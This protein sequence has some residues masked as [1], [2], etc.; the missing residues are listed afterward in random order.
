[1]LLGNYW[2]W[3]FI[4]DDVFG[5]Q[6]G[7]YEIWNS[8][9]LLGIQFMKPDL[10]IS[11]VYLGNIFFGWFYRS[12]QKIYFA[13][14]VAS[15]LEIFNAWR[16]ISNSKQRFSPNILRNAVINGDKKLIF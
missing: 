9:F 4:K 10:V 6:N 11:V 8:Q 3:F 16:T 13:R 14:D 2:D 12:N 1:M 5:R 7:K 15:L